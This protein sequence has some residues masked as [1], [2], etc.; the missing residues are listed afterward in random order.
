MLYARHTRERVSDSSPEHL[1]QIIKASFL[2]WQGSHFQLPQQAFHPHSKIEQSVHGHLL[3]FH[4]ALWPAQ[5]SQGGTLPRTDPSFTNT[6]GNMQASRLR[7]LTEKMKTLTAWPA[8]CKTE[9]DP[10]QDA[11]QARPYLPP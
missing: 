1:S 10:I 5:M 11:T 3:L 7:G 2:P 6:L 4:Y 9:R 8:L